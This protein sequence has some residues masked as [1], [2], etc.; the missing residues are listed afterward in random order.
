MMAGKAILFDP[1]RCSAC[2]GC[3]V[4]CK[5]WNEHKATE[6]TFWGSYENPKELSPETWV[7]MR[8]TEVVRNGKF[9]WLFTRRAC[10][11]CTNASCATVCPVGAIFHTEEGFVHI[12]K[13]WCIGCGT[14]TQACPFNIPHLDHKEGIASKCSACTSVGLNRLAEGQE[15]ACVKS[16]PPDAL[17]YGDRDQLVTEGNKRVAVLKS[18][19]N[20]NAMLYGENELGGLHVMYVLDDNPSVYGLPEKPQVA[21]KDMVGKWLAGLATAGI[22]AGLPLLWIFRRREEMQNKPKVGGGA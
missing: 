18:K 21:T 9:S 14:C 2:R 3:Q 11:H 1:S 20:T 17:T 5:Q 6:T 13:E 10:M 7:K 4:S 12:D 16:C 15:P 22:V 8:F 19:G